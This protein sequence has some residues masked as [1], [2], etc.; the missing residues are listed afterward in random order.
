MAADPVSKVLAHL[1]HSVLPGDSACLT[2]GQ[3]LECFL[4]RRDAAAFEALVRR[5]G[6]MVLGVCRRIVGHS[7]DAEDAFQATFL[8]LLRKGESV[9][10]REAVGSWLHGVACR[11]ALRARTVQVRRRTRE[12]QVR[13]LPELAAKEEENRAELW[14][15]LDQELSGLPEKLRL[16][17]VLCDLEGRTRREVARQ[18]RVPD[19]TLSNRLEKGRRLLARRLAR[20]G[21]TLSAAAAG[22]LLA[23]E[24][25]ATTLP[26]SLAA[27]TVQA[28][29]GAAVGPLS[30]GLISA[31]V[32]SLTQEVL[33][34]MFL[35][36]LK[37][38]LVFLVAALLASV[39]AGMALGPSADA[40][41]TRTEK[42]APPP[43][44]PDGEKEK[45]AK[46]NQRLKEELQAL[47]DQ[48]AVAKA[49]AELRAVE[50]AQLMEQINRLQ[51][52]ILSLKSK[53]EDPKREPGVPA[54]VRIGAPAG[55][56][57]WVASGKAKF[58]KEPTVEAPGRL[59][60]QEGQTHRL[61]LANIPEHP[62]LELYP[63]VE[64][65][66]G[67]DRGRTFL[68]HN[69]I[70][71]EFVEEDFDQVTKGK[72]LVTR[73]LYLPAA[74]GRQP[75]L[76]DARPTADTIVS[77][78]LEP[79]YDAVEEAKKRGSILAVVRLGDIDLESP[80]PKP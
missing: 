5:H 47:R 9:R 68:A 61:K 10:P 51:K 48:L 66:S 46:E 12:K 56:K 7:Q 62:G 28:A 3:L 74:K 42:P 69:A 23:Q 35:N 16:P 2:D 22:V 11:T 33:R 73:V 39:G 32:V 17:I 79:G 26:T 80:T 76:E 15:V 25:A 52:E 29:A 64:V 58:S 72:M 19:G 67:D 13:D 44:A 50:A 40:Q 31:S 77:Y 14:P 18:L 55:M 54:Q 20:R 60:L 71:V 34:A 21:V 57:V 38:V 63:T 6:A 27:A 70:P 75:G 37:I 24:A 8:V 49:T 65:V 53:L 45:L 78:R 4:A 59:N 41:E 1:H 36:K 30:T 43:G